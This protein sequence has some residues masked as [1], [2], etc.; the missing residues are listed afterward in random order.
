VAD[1]VDKARLGAW[2][3]LRSLVG[4]EPVR[5]VTAELPRRI[6]PHQPKAKAAIFGKG[7]EGARL[8]EAMAPIQQE[9]DAALE[10]LHAAKGYETARAQ[11]TEFETYAAEA[12]LRLGWNEELSDTLV[13]LLVVA[14]AVGGPATRQV[15]AYN[16]TIGEFIDPAEEALV[17]RLNVHRLLLAIPPTEMDLRLVAAA[18]KHSEEMAA[19]N[20]F[21]HASPTKSLESPW[22]RAGREGTS[23]GGE[24]IAAGSGSGVAAFRMW[25]YSQGHHTIMIGGSTIGIGHREGRWTLMTG[26]SRLRPPLL[27]KFA[28]YIRERYRAGDDPDKLFPLA[29]WC[30]TSGL[31]NQAADELERLLALDPD[32]K[33]A[34][35]TLESLRPA[36]RKDSGSK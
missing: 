3:T 36:P 16:R 2:K 34:A 13:S 7:F 22:G 29:K 25:Y 33:Q 20:Y 24:C 21:S 1:A 23:A 10:A 15:L 32:H 35:K 11:L 4:S 27:P 31:T 26:G 5:R 6:A 30:A 14:H 9:L 18:R 17:A 19:K 28:H 12:G 8:D